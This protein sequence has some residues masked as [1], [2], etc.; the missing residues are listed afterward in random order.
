MSAPAIEKRLDVA[1]AAEPPSQPEKPAEQP[2]PE[3]PPAPAPLNLR[4]LAGRRFDLVK[5]PRFHWELDE[6]APPEPGSLRAWGMQ[7][8][9]PAWLIAA[10]AAGQPVNKLWAESEFD[11]LAQKTATLT[12]GRKGA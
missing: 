12:L 6:R 11:D 5:K 8:G 10:M 9:A 7:K 1:P 2:A 4:E 3:T